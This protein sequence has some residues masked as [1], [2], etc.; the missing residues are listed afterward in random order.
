MP[1]WRFSNFAWSKLVIDGVEYPTSEHY[2]Q[3]MKFIKT[4]PD[5]AEVVRLSPNPHECKKLSNDR[6]HPIDPKWNEN[7]IGV[8][9]E[10]L[11]YKAL[12]N[13]E[14]AQDLIDTGDRQIIEASPWDR[15]WGEGKDR[16]GQN[17]LG[18]LLEELRDRLNKEYQY[19]FRDE[20][21]EKVPYRG[22]DRSGGYRNKGGGGNRPGGYRPRPVNGEEG[23]RR[24]DEDGVESE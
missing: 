6:S 15:F 11:Y 18:K 20:V 21:P 7:R 9:K 17:M 19:T 10:V 5:Y 1:G 8:M 3:T 24:R 14:F 2:F 12:Q 4:D 22:G 23:V 13:P 16:D